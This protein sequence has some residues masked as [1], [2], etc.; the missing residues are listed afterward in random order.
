MCFVKLST[1]KVW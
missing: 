1:G